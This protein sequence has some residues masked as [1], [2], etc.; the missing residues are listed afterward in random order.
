[1]SISSNWIDRAATNAVAVRRYF[2]AASDHYA[3]GGAQE[4]AFIAQ[5][6]IAL[7]FLPARAARVLDIGCGPAVLAL[8]VPN[9]ASG[10]RHCRRVADTARRAVKGLLG[11][12]P[13]ASERFHWN[14]CMPARLN[15]ELRHGA[16]LALNRARSGLSD[17]PFGRWIGAQYMIKAR[18]P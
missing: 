2:D 16:S 17:S 13:R 5:K 14:P 11:K 4:H 7:D 3:R 1:M 18:K 9:R 12:S 15:Q 6:R 10:Y 8:A